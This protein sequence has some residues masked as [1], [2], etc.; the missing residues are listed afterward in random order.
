M[1]KRIRELLYRS[2]DVSLSR[3]EQHRLEEVLS[4]SKELREEKKQIESMR[5]AI[6]ESPAPSFQPF[7][8]ER[9][10]KRI[11]QSRKQKGSK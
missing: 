9:V 11:R 6:S 5:R 10:M 2:F 8:A 4:H 1:D 3:E 7:L